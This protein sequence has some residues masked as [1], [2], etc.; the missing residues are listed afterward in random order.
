MSRRVWAAGLTAVATALGVMM[1]ENVTAIS[2]VMSAI[3]VVLGLTSWSFPK[4]NK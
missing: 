2:A 1:P 4:M 3:A